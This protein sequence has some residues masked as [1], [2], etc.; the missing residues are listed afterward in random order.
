MERELNY[1]SR[2]EYRSS[3]SKPFYKRWWVWL[4]IILVVT[5]GVRGIYNIGE[6]D[7]T[8]DESLDQEKEEKTNKNDQ[9][10]IKDKEAEA[11]NSEQEDTPEESNYED[12]K[13]TYVEFEGEPY[14][15]S[16]LS[17]IIVLGDA[18]YK[19]FDRWEFNMTSTILDKKIE[20]NTLTIE[21]D[22]DENEMWGL[23]S[24][25]GT[26]QFTLD[27]KGDT[28]TLHHEGSEDIIYYS[29]S[30]QDLQSHYSQSEIDFARIIMTINSVPS[31][32][33]WAVWESEN[34]GSKPVVRISQNESGDSTD[35]SDQVKYPEDVTHINL[36]EQG[37]Y[38]GVITY[39]SVRDGYI[40]IYPMPLDFHQEDQSDEGYRQLGQEAIDSADEIEI[41]AFEPYE[42]ADF[43]GNVEFVYE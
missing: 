14:N 35:V 36:T 21:L 13:G 28:K 3:F 38:N 10:I 37:M 26:E 27:D 11:T 5:I 42:V 20:G 31:L 9:D 23:H 24:E 34:D 22:S 2:R 25:T 18:H 17:D 8:V 6:K 16:I 40:K 32:D 4:V 39:S 33:S 41:E 7:Q 1:K 15:S 29:M 12:F 19:T 30:S 43:I